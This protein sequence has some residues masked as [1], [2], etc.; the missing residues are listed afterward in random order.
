VRV[1]LAGV[2]GTTAVLSYDSS[3]L[4]AAAE[5]RGR[6]DSFSHEIFIKTLTILF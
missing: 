2:A 6:T 5:R 4:T 1:N 3:V